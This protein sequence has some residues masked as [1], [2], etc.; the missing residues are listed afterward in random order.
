ML[1]S[2]SMTVQRVS[3]GD[4]YG[5]S[6]TSDHHAHDQDFHKQHYQFTANNRL[7]ANDEDIE[8]DETQSPNFN[9]YE[10][11][12]LVSEQQNGV[13]HNAT[14][15]HKPTKQIIHYSAAEFQQ[16]SPTAGYPTTQMTTEYNRQC[17]LR[18][19]KKGNYAIEGGFSLFEF[20]KRKRC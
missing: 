8:H 3:D 18:Y 2:S 13:V 12:H 11:N 6:S 14:S 17:V 4:D 10:L 16:Q 1:V 5:L 15:Q 20:N 19:K 7:D 9:D